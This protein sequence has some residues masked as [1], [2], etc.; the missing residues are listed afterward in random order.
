M[1]YED[2]YN[3]APRWQSPFPSI[4]RKRKEKNKA[5]PPA[6]THQDGS[7]IRPVSYLGGHSMDICMHLLG[8][9]VGLFPP[10]PPPSWTFLAFDQPSL[11]AYSFHTPSCTYVCIEQLI[12]RHPDDTAT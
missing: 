5:Q 2:T 3:E 4:K 8:L 11:K 9:Q 12:L 7:D 1:C 10:L 6:P